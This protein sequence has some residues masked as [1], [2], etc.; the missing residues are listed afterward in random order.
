MCKSD[1]SYHLNTA[2]H[3]AK[4]GGGGAL[5]GL[6][7]AIP[8]ITNVTS[9]HNQERVTQLNPGIRGPE[10]KTEKTGPAQRMCY[11]PILQM[12]Q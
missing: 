7:S 9:T 2:Y 6:K 10:R 11:F 3:H 4:A 1:N 5:Q 12:R 8:E